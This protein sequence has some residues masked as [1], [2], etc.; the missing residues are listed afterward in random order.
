MA[1]TQQLARVPLDYLERCRRTAA[2]SSEG[3]PR[4]DPPESEALDLDWAIWCLI[5]F[6]RRMRI[7]DGHLGVL[8][9]SING[10][11][12][13]A[14]GCLDHPEVYDGFG[15]PPALLAPEAVTDVAQALSRIDVDELLRGLPADSTAAAVACGL[16]GFEGHPRRY[17]VE[18]FNLLRNFY[19][20]ASRRGLAVVTWTD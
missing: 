16:E 18:H 12:D 3:D 17:L 4:W 19:C 9:R 5:S 6:C 11:A 15:P 14:V 10:D 20:A 2:A 7:A 13:G 1:L 8:E